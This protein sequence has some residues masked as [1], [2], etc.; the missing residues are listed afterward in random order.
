MIHG[1]PQLDRK[2]A[3]LALLCAELVLLLLGVGQ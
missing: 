2:T 3:L 1:F